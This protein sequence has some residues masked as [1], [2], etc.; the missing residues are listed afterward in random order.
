MK[1]LVIYDSM[2]GNTKKIAESIA[3]V[4]GNSTRVVMVD[5]V[6]K[7]DLAGLGLLVVGS[8]IL[9]WKPSKKKRRHF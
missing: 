5:Q 7:N 2:Y 3:A 4:L 8:P 6:K 1:N 9:G